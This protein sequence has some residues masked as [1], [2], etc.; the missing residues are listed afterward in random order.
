MRLWPT[1]HRGLLPAG[2][3]LPSSSMPLASPFEV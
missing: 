3:I 1:D 2:L